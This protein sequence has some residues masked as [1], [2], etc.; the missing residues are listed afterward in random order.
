MRV[1]LETDAKNE[2]DDQHAIAY[3]LFSEERFHV[4][5]ITVNR[6]RSG[7][8]VDQHLA[9]AR[10]VV[11]LCDRESKVPV[12][13]GA[14]KAFEE[15]R[16]QI[17]QPDF[18]GAEAVNF[19]I[20]QALATNR[21]RL[22]LIP[23]GKL[24]NIAL[25][26]AKEP[27]IA[28]KVRIVWLGS[29]YPEPGEYNQDNDEPALNYILDTGVEFEI[30]L[31]RYGKPSGTAAVKATLAEVLQK[32][33]GAGPKVS[34]PVEG[35]HGG[36]FACFG[37]YSID[38]FQHIQLE[39]DPPSR[40]LYDMAAV[41]IVKNPAWA[42][43][44]SIPAPILKDGRWVDRPD[45]PRKIVL[46][47]NFDRTAII[48]D[49]Y[50]TMHQATPARI[51]GSAAALQA[52]APGEFAFR[53]RWAARLESHRDRLSFVYGGNPGSALLGGW[54][55][56]KRESNLPGGIVLEEVTWEDPATG[57]EVC[58][59]SKRFQDF[60]ATEWVAR[61][62][63]TGSKDSPLLE[64]V[65]ILDSA[66][67]LPET[68]PAVL[69]WARGGVASF[70]DFAPCSMELQP[71]SPFGLVAREGRSSAEYLPFFNLE[72]DGAGV[73]LAVG[74]TGRWA[75]NFE[76][77]T[78][79]SVRATVGM[80]RTRL[81]LHPGEE[82]RTP[83]MLALFYQGDRWRGQNLLRRFILAHHRPFKQGKPLVA[84][85]TYGNWGGTH[86]DVHLSNI[87][88]ILRE[89]LPM[90]YYWIDAG[91]YGK[92]EPEELPTWATNVGDWRVKPCLHPQGFKMLSEVLRN[93]GRELMLWFEP[94]R[95]YRNTPWH[96][97]HADWL[98]DIGNDNLL[99]DLGKPEARAF[100]TNFIGDRVAEF[101]L[102][103]YRQDF[104][105]DPGPYWDKNDA[106]DRQGMSEIRY[107]EGLYAFWDALLARDPNLIIDNCASGGRR[108]DLETIGRSTPFW[109]TD[110]PRDPIAH[111]CHTYGLLPWV[112]FSAT[113][114]DVAGDDY[115]FRS[116][117]CSSL[118]INW[119]HSGDGPQSPYPK[120]FPFDW[121]RKT[122][123]QYLSIRDNYYGD[124]YPLTEY[125]QADDVWM[126]YQL[127]RPEAGEG[128]IVALR[129]PQ[130]LDESAR[131]G[132]HGL[133][134][135][136][137]YACTDLDTKKTIR[138]KGEAL[139]REGL[140]IAIAS[141]PGSALIEYLKE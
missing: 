21:S 75:V 125:S 32:M 8:G 56:R 60:P 108:I 41:A 27:S 112:P 51:E 81:V 1:I 66:F 63:N 57:L 84:P 23:V 22:V 34:P 120:G 19:I 87:R 76:S 50:R 24:T 59:S 134:P 11:Q 122:L 58:V 104:N 128:L 136:A 64:N 106:P 68:K 9:E 72:G 109:R 127:D 2:V 131:F 73:V 138:L 42:Q 130:C 116:S 103:C 38:L 69:H 26:L 10:R 44:A 110:G 65:Q 6:T 96:R 124:Y 46:W 91:W 95:V 90:D 40:A 29:N 115:E 67:A 16:G 132:L 14:D 45:N 88:D 47:Q 117:M 48:Q 37:D 53:D 62:K 137:I 83:S 5:G 39:G 35:R 36:L 13:R 25:A 28:S 114:Q 33:P 78:G 102:G 129:R 86:A 107:I 61:F 18:D 54:N 17:D 70:D 43:A 126:V 111:Q 93:N 82:I 141:R 79:G 80:S 92:P 94:E 85:I 74:W 98:I 118:C 77:G 105:M 101:G 121:A 49:F 3:L 140:S 4:E 71:G 15:I 100:V 7:G 12:L 30:A 119:E 31:V 20:E 135:E 89:R 123:E 99:M 139:M 55:R 133:D 113:S 97:E 52:I